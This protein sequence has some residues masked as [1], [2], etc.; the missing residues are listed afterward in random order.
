[1]SGF[2]SEHA[3]VEDRSSPGGWKEATTDNCAGIHLAAKTDLQ[4]TEVLAVTGLPEYRRIN[5]DRTKCSS[6]HSGGQG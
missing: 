1:M 3:A 4:D 5:M 6:R 2:I